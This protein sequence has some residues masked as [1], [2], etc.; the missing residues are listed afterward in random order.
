MRI[1][2]QLI[3][4]ANDDARA[5]RIYRLRSRDKDFVVQLLLD[6][7]QRGTGVVKGC[8]HSEML[9]VHLTLRVYDYNQMGQVGY[10]C[11]LSELQNGTVDTED[12]T[13]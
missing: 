11:T 7:I 9:T 10:I 13:V 5:L 1:T 6:L 2:A 4:N 3:L 8:I 12:F